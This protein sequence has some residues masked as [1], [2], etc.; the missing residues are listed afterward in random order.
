MNMPD[1]KSVPV[2][3]PF[4][5]PLAGFIPRLERIWES[6]WVTNGGPQH[7]ELEQALCRYLDVPFVSLFN[8]GTNA[9]ITALQA[10]D[11]PEGSE[12]ITTPFSFVATAH[13]VRWNR[14]MPVFADVDPVH[15]NIDPAVVERAITPATRALLPVHVYGNPCDTA[16]IADIAKRHKLQVL[17]DAAHLFGVTRPAR[18][19]LRDG[20]LSVLSFHATKVF[21]TFEGGAIVSHTEEMKH[22]IDSLRNF[23]FTGETTADHV[24]M[25]GKMNEVQAAFGLLSLAHIDAAIAKRRAVAERYIAALSGIHG[26]GVIR[27]ADGV[28][29]AWPYFPITV[30][31]T[32]YGRS[33]DELFE[34]FKRRDI[35]PRRYFYP[36]ISAF[37]PYRDL[38]SAVP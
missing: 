5:P 8:N 12:V 3:R 28:G 34:E 29:P 26:I 36:L 2:T 24:G 17:Y 18:P 38:P 4:L 32:R 31:A 6:G 1:R 23:G 22:K 16:A 9:L 30:D 21:G 15:G 35:L 20:D 27:P 37:A 13:T 14:C 10:L 11:L 25:N 19:P 33:R 7:Q